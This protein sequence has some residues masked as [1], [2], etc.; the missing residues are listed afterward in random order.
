[1]ITIADAMPGDEDAIAALCREL[2]DYYGQPTAG[3]PQQRA[4]RVRA[5][6]FAG[7]PMARALLA[8]DGPSLAG[9]ASYSF[10]WPAA[11][12]S[13]SLYLKELY[14][15]AACRRA[16]TGTLLIN[17]LFAVAAEKGCARVE[18]TTDA[19]NTSARAF[20]EALGATPLPAK[21]FYRTATLP[22]GA[23]TPQLRP[24][25]S[26]D[27]APPSHG[28]G[29]T[30]ATPSNRTA[31]VLA[32]PDA[33]TADYERVVMVAGGPW[34]A[35]RI[36]SSGCIAAWAVCAAASPPAGPWSP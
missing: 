28:D 18:W 25:P 12:L 7:Q 13:A 24:R 3:T 2:D 4:D 21:I 32:I 17:R 35:R 30:T 33:P 36:A 15:A 26:A 16:G 11:G 5:V 9:L 6:F 31:G 8:W 20:Y 19:G 27:W 22:A 29:L 14:V 1:L 34:S 23:P 10:L